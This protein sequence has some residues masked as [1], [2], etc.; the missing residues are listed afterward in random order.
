MTIHKS[1]GLSL[2]NAIIDVGNTIFNVGQ[3][4]VAL[5]RVTELRG[6]HLINFDPHSVKASSSAIKEYNRLRKNYRSDLPTI[7]IPD[8]RWQK[9]C[10][11]IWAVEEH[12]IQI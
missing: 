6:L 10:D 8:T 11:M 4:Y 3:I 2:K 1:Q 7:P 5:S 9:V 12:S